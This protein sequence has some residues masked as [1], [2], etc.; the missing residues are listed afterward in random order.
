ME[1]EALDDI[2]RK[3]LSS[4]AK[5]SAVLIHKV[6]HECIEKEALAMKKTNV[7]RTF[8]RSFRLAAAIFIVVIL[9]VG[10]ALAVNFGGFT[11]L[12]G[13][14]GEDQALML[15]PVVKEIITEDGIRAKLVAMGVFDNVV[16][17]YLMLEDTVGNRFDGTY[18]RDFRAFA[19]MGVVDMP[20]LETPFV[21]FTLIDQA[22]DGILT[23]H[24]RALFGRS[25]AGEEIAISMILQGDQRSQS[26]YIDLDLSSVT[27]VTPAAMIGG[28]PI[29]PP[30][31]LD[32][33]VVFTE[34]IPTPDAAPISNLTEEDWEVTRRIS[35]IG[36]IDGNL[37]VQLYT[38]NH[39]VE[40]TIS[41]TTPR[42]DPPRRGFLN[43]VGMSPIIAFFNIDEHGNIYSGDFPSNFYTEYIFTDLNLDELEIYIPSMQFSVAERPLAW[44]VEVSIAPYENRLAVSGLDIPVRNIIVREVIVTPFTVLIKGESNVPIGIPVQTIRIHTTDGVRG[45][46]ISFGLPH[47]VRYTDE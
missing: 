5:P 45:H 18:G 28:I 1:N 2:L 35:S 17:I 7:K 11:R 24:G 6:K 23:L 20:H 46:A 30:N 19:R 27:E 42:F 39:P 40:N 22:D 38:A 47:G 43:M 34:M 32:I 36:I 9:A 33:P 10:T 14:V 25:V 15:E 29:L 26:G 31:Q 21:E 13:I 44:N 12:T 16:D 3:H 8:N 37:H 41:V 4:A